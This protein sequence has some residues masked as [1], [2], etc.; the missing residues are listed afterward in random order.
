[1]IRYL[2]AGESHGE[3]L[4]TIIEGLP[5]G[6]KLTQ[7]DMDR[8]LRR[9]QS[10]YG[11]GKRMEIEKDS[12]KLLSGIRGGKTTGAPIAIS[13]SNKDWK[14]W[15]ENMHPFTPFA[16]EKVTAPRPGHADLSGAIKYGEVDLRNIMERASARE[17]AARTAVGALAKALLREFDIDVFSYVT[18]I[19]KAQAPT[20]KVT[21]KKII[22]AQKRA[23]LFCL[24]PTAE[25]LMIAE[26]EE[27]ASAGDSLGGVFEI[28]VT[29]VPVGL[30]SY[31]HWD[32]RLDGRLSQAVMS[33]QAIKGV[34]IGLG[35]EAARR[36]GS[37]VH[38]EIFY[39]EQKSGRAEAKNLRASD[40]PSLFGF[41]RT[42]N[43]AGGIEGGM[44]NGMP[45]VIRA[46]MKPIPTLQTPLKT[47]DIITKKTVTA[48][49][50]RA[51]VCAVPAASVVGEA[52]VA[53]EIVRA[54]QDK[55]GGDTL[56]EMKRNYASYQTYTKDL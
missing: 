27:A 25:K 49:K 52:V 5:S 14:N 17:T 16:G 55:F 22:E 11:R 43:R 13:I 28:I 50:E 12:A 38:D 53:I 2:T 23:L 8:E 19:G 18:S 21:P 24:D 30:G 10:G 20:T 32:R 41:Y 48:A 35:F 1:M 3:A 33:I 44:T 51:D 15:K 46:A 45:I 37:K 42:T 6:L 54:M 39:L 36:V 47:V 7:K 29:G 31:T 40:L 4:I 26:I 9:R 34:E 56:A